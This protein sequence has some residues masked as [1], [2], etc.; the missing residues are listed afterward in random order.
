MKKSLTCSCVL[1]SASLPAADWNFYV[2]P[3][4][5]FMEI[6]FNTPTDVKGY[7]AGITAG[8]D[9]ECCYFFSNLEFEGT[10]NA[11]PITSTSCDRSDIGEYFIDFQLGTV[12]PFNC[13]R[14]RFKPYI[15]FGWDRFYN[16]QDPKTIGLCYRYDKLFIPVGFYL[17]WIFWDCN[18]WGVQFEWRPDVYSCLKLLSIPLKNQCEQAFRV[19]VPL[20]FND[21]SCCRRGFWL[22][23]VPFFDWNQFGKVR[24]KNEDGVALPIPALKRWDLGLRL[25]FGWEF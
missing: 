15:G 5:H 7:A 3:H 6:E 22:G 10:W 1:L 19:Q 4:F 9:L 8:I 25:I 17:D 21:H 23:V 2:G 14:L 12:L 13:D 16:E 24:E 11:G 18:S 20:R